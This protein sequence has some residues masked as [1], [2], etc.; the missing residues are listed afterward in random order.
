MLTFLQKYQKLFFALVTFVIVSSFALFGVLDLFD[1][2]PPMHEDREIGKLI[3]G[4]SMMMG[5]VRRLSRFIATDAEDLMYRTDAPVNLCNNGVIRR[6]L[7]HTG[8][9]DLLVSAYF[10]PLKN[11][12]SKKL[13]RAKTYRSYQ[14]AASPLVN[15]RA[16][17]ERFIPP[18]VQGIDVL[19]GQR[20]V[21]IA[22]FSELSKLYM[23][24]LACPPE[25]TRRFLSFYESQ[26]ETKDPFL[27]H[28]DLALFGF[29][30]ASDWFGSNFVD[31]AAE[32]ILNGAKAALGQGY[33][34]TFEE[35]KADLQRNF[36]ASVKKI[37]EKH[38]GSLSF[39]SHLRMLGFDE[40]EA[41][42]T[43]RSV[44]L[45]RRYFESASQAMIVD[46]LPYRDFAS[47]SRE[48]SSIQKFEWLPEMQL[49]TGQD[50]IE[51]QVY[52]HALGGKLNSTELP[53]AILSLETIASKTPELVQTTY[54]ANVVSTSVKEVGLMA[55]AKEV[56]DWQLESANWETLRSSFSF[57]K[58]AHT[59][60]E[61]LIQL[62]A[63][64]KENR[65]QVDLFV[66]NKWV[67][68]NP[69]AIQEQL[70]LKKGE[71]R[72]ISTSSSC[73]SMP[74]IK[75]P[76]ELS[77]LFG[78]NSKAFD[79]QEGDLFYRFDQIE[80]IDQPHVLTFKEA[81][82]KGI[83][84]PLSNRFLEA[85]YK[86]IRE[87]FPSQFQAK[88]GEWKAF[89]SVK[90]E[91]AKHVFADLFNAIG[92]SK[93]GLAYYASHR[94]EIPT[95]RALSALQKDPQDTTWISLDENE[96]PLIRQFK[97]IKSECVV[98]KMAEDEWMREKLFV[99]KPGVFSPVSVPENGKISFF[100]FEKTNPAN[101]P[102][103]EQLMLGKEILGADA[104]RFVAEKLLKKTKEKNAIVIPAKGGNDESL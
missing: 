65:L 89:F 14:S 25:L 33:E 40:K 64:S 81:K 15:A 52:L 77:Q 4:S 48:S 78:K 50:L 21:S 54:I 56:L 63:L 59:N 27:S 90:E 66:R 96:E 98:P 34:V 39:A 8:I 2:N 49:K 12:L 30:S 71:E 94:L 45:F 31:L 23:Q 84:E 73:V 5:D 104:K 3:N 101:A 38:R 103:L 19:K 22:T 75:K 10:D 44:L 79:Y 17:W 37:P 36:Q 28:A 47:F 91:V 76:I 83:L 46:Q 70:A 6:D 93:E 1:R 99:M 29:H 97:L 26:G 88:E 61:R 9:A 74:E 92:K 16:V 53:H 13:E 35:A 82:T 42:N 57:L 60:E 32:F 11:D 58:K 67:E 87:S 102:I 20:E 55:R 85:E 69:F 24:Q 80:K 7:L 86:K 62:E 41:V 100:Y 43:W 51:F 18:I 95:K 72:E 68:S